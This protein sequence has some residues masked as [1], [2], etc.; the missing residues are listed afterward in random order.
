MIKH[1]KILLLL[2]LLTSG[3]VCAEEPIVLAS[4]WVDMQMG[5]LTTRQKIA[6]MVMVAMN[7]SHQTSLAPATA[8]VGDEDARKLQ[9]IERKEAVMK[10]VADEHIGGI[11]CFRG[12]PKSQADLLTQLQQL[13]LD[14]SALPLLVSQ[15]AEWGLAM[16]LT[17]VPRLPRNM[18]LGAI[19]NKD[20]LRVFGKFVGFMCRVVGVHVNFAPVIDVNTNPKNPVI[21]TRAL[22]EDPFQV[23]HNAWYIISGMLEENV[24]PCAKHAPGHGDTIVDSHKD[25]PRITHDKKRLQRVE[26]HPFRKLI[27]EFKSKIGLM[28]A[29]ITVPALTEDENL[30]ASLS[31]KVIKG[32]IR[33]DLGFGGLVFPDA[34]NMRAITNF[35]SHSQ[36]ALAAFMAGNDILLYADDVTEAINV[37]ETLVQS[38]KVYAQQL[39]D[40]VRRILQVKKQIIEQ[41]RIMP[42]DIER[43]V[44]A[45]EPRILALKRTLY[46]EAVTL[47]R[48]ERGMLPIK[49][50]DI[51]IGYIKIGGSKDSLA[52]VAALRE[53]ITVGYVGLD[54]KLSDLE[55]VLKTMSFCNVMVVAIGRVHDKQSPYGNVSE[56]SPVLNDMLKRIHREAKPVTLS[57]LVS[58]YALKFFQGESTCIE[59]YED[60][61]EAEIG[62]LKVIFGLKKATGK[63]P[64]SLPPV[65]VG[66]MMKSRR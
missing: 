64:I 44:F 5:R 31:D 22:H 38:N 66:A 57:L 61:V 21:G 55:V 49:N 10:M 13:S 26:L 7:S 2:S 65:D 18:T 23:G 14:A 41:G 27:N 37:I 52:E 15:D 45:K 39:D 51:K 17:D 20:L 25:L 43:D 1:G 60:D 29:H 58:P 42:M 3:Y 19:Q 40:S 62:A 46:E 33:Q 28:V 30:P 32:T 6:Q 56:I 8:M 36:A 50:T 4:S 54:Q 9:F 63:L 35:Y 53:G 34:L 47:V 24:L 11:I 48:D 59:A 16:R 12:D